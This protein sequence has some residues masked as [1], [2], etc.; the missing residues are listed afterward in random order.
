[1]TVA[2]PYAL[3]VAEPYALTVAEQV[4]ATSSHTPAGDLMSM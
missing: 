3:T 2:E 1:M 4:S